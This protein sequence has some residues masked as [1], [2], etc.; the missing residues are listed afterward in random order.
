MLLLM[1]AETGSAPQELS[2]FEIIGGSVLIALLFGRFLL[3]K[4]YQ[5]ENKQK[6]GHH[7]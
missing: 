4:G 7:V 6:G 2:M 1:Y 3:H 5:Q